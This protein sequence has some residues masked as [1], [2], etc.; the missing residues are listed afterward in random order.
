M[1]KEFSGQNFKHLDKNKR[2]KILLAS[3]IGIGLL[4]G[5]IGLYRSYALY[6]EKKEFNVLQGQIPDFGYD[7]KLSFKVEN[8]DEVT[9]FPTKES[10]YVGKEVECRDNVKA[11]WDNV[12]WGIKNI[13]GVAEDNPAGIRCTV[14]FKEKETFDEK[15]K[16]GDYIKMTPSLNTFTISGELTGCAKSEQKCGL[17]NETGDQTIN[18]SKLNLWRVIN[19]N[20]DGTIDV[21]SEYVSEENISFYGEEGYKNLVGVLN[22]LASAYGNSEYVKSTR[23]VGY[24]GQTSFLSGELELKGL[25]STGTPE[26]QRSMEA[27]GGGDTS[28]ENDVTF[29][30]NIFGNLNANKESTQAPEAYTFASRRLFWPSSSNNYDI[31]PRC[32][33]PAT[34]NF[35]TCPFVQGLQ[36]G[37]VAAI[38][39]KDYAIRPVLTLKSGLTTSD[40]DGSSEKSPWIL[41]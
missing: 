22:L 8:H 38:R 9:T 25:A 41:G 11:E 2:K 32:V 29:V 4:I 26:W 34:G 24:A 7:V 13:S 28:Y 18:P 37:T 20:E 15:V 19:K 30:K 6:V 39:Q 33:D 40:G 27:K 14:T 35:G 17:E 5:G 10:D 21:I 16:L 3:I 12:S 1:K 23:H 36:V 31:S